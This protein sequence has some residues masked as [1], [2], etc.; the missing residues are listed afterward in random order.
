M[1]LTGVQAALP[2]EKRAQK[3]KLD[4]AKLELVTNALKGQ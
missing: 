2:R 3:E 1:G 4:R